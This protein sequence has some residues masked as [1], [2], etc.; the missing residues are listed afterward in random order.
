M[1]LTTAIEASRGAL[2]RPGPVRPT[3]NARHLVWPDVAGELPLDIHHQV[4]SLL[5]DVLNLEGRA[6]HFDTD[7]PLLGGVPELDSM[8]V[9]AV[10]QEIEVRFGIEIPDDEID[11][12]SFAT[13]GTVVDFVTRLSSR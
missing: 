6:M 1:G 12:S 4:L 2:A 8:A 9:L 3:Y 7:T 13:V 11:G 5:D 10:I